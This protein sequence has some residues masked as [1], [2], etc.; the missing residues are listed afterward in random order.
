MEL[1][2]LRYFVA[3]AEEENVTRAAARLRVAQ[4]SLS[5]QIRD[6]EADLGV[7]LFDHTARSIRLNDAGRHF[8]PEAREALARVEQAVGSVRAFANG[9]AGEFHV[10]YAPSVTT[11]ILP[12]A[13]R[14]F[15]S[16][17]PGV[18]VRL[19]DLST[20]EMVRALHEGE[21]S[22]AL[23][24]QPSNADLEGLEFR[25]IDRFQPVAAMAPD[26][27][28]ATR[29]PIEWAALRGVPLLAYSRDEYPEYHAWLRRVFQG[30]AAPVI[31]SEF[32]SSTSLIVA[33]ESGAGVAL[34][35]EGFENLAGSRLA[36]RA[37][38]EKPDAAFRL[39]VAVRDHDGA[40]R[41]RGFVEA[42]LPEEGG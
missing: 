19:H 2:H 21:I 35:Q 11:R 27:R 29:E 42:C 23:L 38:E 9:E 1:R 28:L 6:L 5:R 32:D 20:G 31:E 10:G 3:V 4:P 40:E 24:V 25:E 8:L 30:S 41:T 15:H 37:L 22:A 14:R 13:L 18:C 12:D 16:E 17:F 7:D 39:G 33:V 34:V 26:H 36:L